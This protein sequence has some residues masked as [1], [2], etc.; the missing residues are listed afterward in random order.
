MS[1]WGLSV[2][3]EIVELGRE[4]L[5]N[6][7]PKKGAY[8][9]MRSPS[10]AVKKTVALTTPLGRIGLLFSDKGIV[11]I[12]LASEHRR[13]G[14]D[15]GRPR[16]AVERR[17]S[18]LLRQ[19]AGGRD[20]AFYLPLDLGKATSFQR[21]VWRATASIPYGET[22]S[23][24]WVAKRVGR[25]HAARAVGQAL[26]ANPVPIIIPCHRVISSSGGLGGFSGGLSMK[27]RLLDREAGRTGGAER[28]RRKQS[29]R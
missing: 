23:Y 27:R 24:A 2:L 10:I 5:R 6:I 18:K 19:Y 28:R 1:V 8:P 13:R 16:S 26:G 14:R 12:D 4:G 15:T 20:V 3:A 29:G 7:F 25:P 22:R 11:R 21:A 9:M 17:A